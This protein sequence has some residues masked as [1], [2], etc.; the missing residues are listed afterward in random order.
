M[1]L[2]FQEHIYNERFPSRLDRWL[3]RTYPGCAQSTIEKNI[4][5]RFIR[6]NGAKTTA[7]ATLAYGD[8]VSVELHLHQ[9]IEASCKHTPPKDVAYDFSKLVLDETPE[10]LV[11]NK[12]SGLD[13]QGGAHVAQNIDDWLKAKSNEYRL[14]HRIDRATSGLLIVAKT[15]SIAVY[16]TKMFREHQIKKHYRAIVCGNIEPNTGQI[17][18][19]ISMC[20][21]TSNVIIDP[22]CGKSAATHY[23][24]LFYNSGGDWSDV[25]LMPQTGRKHQLRV[26]MAAVGHP[27]VGD[28]KYGAPLQAPP[29]GKSLQA[30]PAGKCAPKGTLFLHAWTISFACPTDSGEVKSWCAPLPEYW[31][32]ERE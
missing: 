19:P 23:R 24:R 15:L 8:V 4:R 30:P 28:K 7:G 13:V 32:I 1:S 16:L 2:R 10:F 25:D 12:P 21:G 22:E 6:L 3:K 31:P 9:K 26:H 17:E 29:A 20:A 18:L 27:I 11:I 14:V 5:E